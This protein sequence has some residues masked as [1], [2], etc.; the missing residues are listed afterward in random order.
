M[1]EQ[2]NALSQKLIRQPIN[3]M[4]RRQACVDAQGGATQRFLKAKKI[5]K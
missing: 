2:W 3:C 5:N 4:R 1:Q